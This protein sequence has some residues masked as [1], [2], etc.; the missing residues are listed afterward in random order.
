ML[1]QLSS[2][3]ILLIIFKGISMAHN[4]L[5]DSSNEK[6]EFQPLTYE[7]AE[8]KADSIFNLMTIEEKIALVGG[9]KTFFLRAIPRLN[10]KEVYMTDATQGVHIRQEFVGV[11]LSPYQL[12]KS[13]AFPCPTPAL[14][15]RRALRP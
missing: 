11:D 1:K 3:F 5:N 13:T 15:I 9:D 7:Q 10:M 2:L 12:E 14:L 4:P 8:A 6:Q